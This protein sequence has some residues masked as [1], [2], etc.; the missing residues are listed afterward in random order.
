MFRTA[1]DNSVTTSAARQP[2]NSKPDHPEMPA[3]KPDLHQTRPGQPLSTA[4]PPRASGSSQPVTTAL[5]PS[6]RPNPCGTG[7]VIP[8]PTLATLEFAAAHIQSRVR[9]MAR[10]QTRC[11]PNQT[12]RIVCLAPPPRAS[13]SSH[14]IT[15]PHPSAR[16]TPCGTGR[17]L[18]LRQ[19]AT[20][21]LAAL[22][23]SARPAARPPTPNTAP[24]PDMSKDTT[25]LAHT[26]RSPTIPV[27]ADDGDQYR[28]IVVR[29]GQ[30]SAGLA[31]HR[32]NVDPH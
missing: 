14:P 20:L 23:I 24:D 7:R 32:P 31:S 2:T 28:V 1:C 13:G 26:A 19:P 8:L 12:A 18:A 17:V 3:G 29:P 16:S 11:A 25:C 30:P 15:T 4:P 21:E 5:P 22:N 9:G 10:R 27:P 6:A